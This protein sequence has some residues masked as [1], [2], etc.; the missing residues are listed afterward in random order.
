MKPPNE[1]LVSIINATYISVLKYFERIGITITVFGSKVILHN[2]TISE[3]FDNDKFDIYDN[4]IITVYYRIDNRNIFQTLKIH[5]FSVKFCSSWFLHHV[6]GFHD[7][8]TSLYFLNGAFKQFIFPSTCHKLAEALK[9][10]VNNYFV[11]GRL[12]CASN[13]RLVRMRMVVDNVGL[14]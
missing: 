11:H 3:R 2:N 7:G 1:L 8:S 10:S 4:L 13:A 12:G 9:Y 14:I 5:D 6:V